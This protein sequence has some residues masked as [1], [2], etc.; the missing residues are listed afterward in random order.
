MISHQSSV[1]S[2]QLRPIVFIV[3]PTASGKTAV[4]YLLARELKAEI[5]SCDSMAIYRQPDIITSKPYP[6]MLKEIPHH[7]VN[8]ISVSESYNVFDYYREASAKI[9]ELCAKK[10]LPI[11]CGGSGLYFKALCDGIF[12]GPGKNDFLRQELS[13]RAE[14]EG[15]ISLHE[16]LRQVD[17]RSAEKIPV[18]DRRRIIRALEVYR[19]TGVPISLKQKQAEGLCKKFP[20]RIFGLR[21]RRKELYERINARVDNMFVLG[22]LD[23]VFHLLKL[24]LSHTAQR[25]IGINE[26]RQYLEG[27]LT[28]SQARELMKKNTRNFAKRQM[29][30]FR[31]DKKVEWIDCDGLTAE[32][33]KDGIIARI[34]RRSS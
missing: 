10:V 15:N 7:L 32:N 6:F 29:T 27:N 33:I 12:E 30:W 23:E 24:N 2:H 8:I 3:G 20:V 28:E 9:N 4:S 16:Q 5:I 25:I 17:P 14:N 11:V 21:L 1:T 22:A 13:R 18:N 31:A 19:E 34:E 26:I